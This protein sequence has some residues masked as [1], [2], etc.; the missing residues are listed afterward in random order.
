VNAQHSDIAPGHHPA[1]TTARLSLDAPREADAPSILAI[2]GDPRTTVHNPSDHVEDLPEARRLVARWQSH[3]NDH[4]FGY[5]CVS[6]HGGTAI[7]GYCGVKHMTAAGLPVL[8]LLYRFRPEV[9]G[10]GYAMEAACAVVAWVTAHRPGSTVL[11]RVRPDNIASQRV[12]LHVGLRRD[13][14]LDEPGEDGMDLAFTDRS[15]TAGRS[16]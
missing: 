12:A 11:A 4:G 10:R 3:W 8:N 2:A 13:P 1:L 7:V 16:L 6:E 9:W 14:A 15:G 5:W